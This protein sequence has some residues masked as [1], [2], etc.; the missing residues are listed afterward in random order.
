MAN[1]KTVKFTNEK[2]NALV[3]VRNGLK[4]QAQSK[5]LEILADNFDGTIVNEKGGFS[6]PLAVDTVS[7]KTI[8]AHLEMTV[9]TNEAKKT[10]RK[11]KKSKSA[12]EPVVVPVLF[13]DDEEEYEEE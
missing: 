7:G 10:E 6:V 5:I 13:E 11:A 9:S 12:G 2:G 1:L 3:A 8:F 4:A